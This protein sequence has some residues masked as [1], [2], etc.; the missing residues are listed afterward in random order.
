MSHMHDLSVKWPPGILS[1][2]WGTLAWYLQR[3]VLEYSYTED[4]MMCQKS[5]Q[6]LSY[7]QQAIA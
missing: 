1:H 5:W 2:S 6:I 4:S 7:R 3:T